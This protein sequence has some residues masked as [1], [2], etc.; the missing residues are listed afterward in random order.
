MENKEIK[1]D[2]ILFAL[3]I[4]G[5]GNYE[6]YDVLVKEIKQHERIPNLDIYICEIL[7]DNENLNGKEVRM[8][9]NRLFTERKH[10]LECAVQELEEIAQ[11]TRN[12]ILKAQVEINKE[13]LRIQKYRE[14]EQKTIEIKNAILSLC[15]LLNET[16]NDKLFQYMFEHIGNQDEFLTSIN[17]LADILQREKKEIREGSDRLLKAIFGEGTEETED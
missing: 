15:V 13:N 16:C 8:T 11:D 4:L 3:L 1:I 2:D 6:I 12:E 10:A 9:K 5:Y 14:R 17:E 7:S